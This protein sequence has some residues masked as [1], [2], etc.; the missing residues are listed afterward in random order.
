MVSQV[1]QSQGQP[2]KKEQAGGWT[3][4][5]GRVEVKLGLILDASFCFVL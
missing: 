3:R 5:A 1:N 4:E 2:E